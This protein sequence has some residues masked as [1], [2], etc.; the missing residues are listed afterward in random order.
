MWTS[1]LFHMYRNAKYMT[2]QD[3]KKRQYLEKMLHIQSN[4]I[5]VYVGS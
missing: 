1:T 5:G 3:E 2:E 4:V